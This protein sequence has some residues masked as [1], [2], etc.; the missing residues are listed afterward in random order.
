M[1]GAGPRPRGGGIALIGY[2]TSGKTTVGRLVADRLGRSF[3]DSDAEVEKRTRRSIAN[4]FKHAGPIGFPDVGFRYE[5]SRTIHDLCRESPRAVL[6]TGGGAVLLDSNR[7]VLRC[8]GLVVWLC[9]P[10]SLLI[11]RLRLDPGGRP[12]LTALGLLDEVVHLLEE[13]EPLYRAAADLIVDASADPQTVADEIVRVVGSE[14][15]GGAT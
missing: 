2:R 15:K 1:S 4:Y 10:A 6:A 13:R 12:A 8:F 3:L 7:D 5:E 9:A 11:E 14:A